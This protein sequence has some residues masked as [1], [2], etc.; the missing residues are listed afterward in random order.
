MNIIFLLD[1]IISYYSEF[2]ILD[3]F[4]IDDNIAIRIYT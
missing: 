3:D 4:K 1:T 2:I